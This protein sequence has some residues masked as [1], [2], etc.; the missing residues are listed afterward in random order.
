MQG[1]LLQQSM[2]GI[3]KH[4]TARRVSL[5]FILFVAG[6][7]LLST[8]IPQEMDTAPAQLNAWR[9][10]HGGMLWLI[11]FAHLQRV[12]AQPWFAIAILGAAIS[13]GV[14]AWDQF[15]VAGKRLHGTGI[16]SADEIASNV[17]RQQVGGIAKL[18]RYQPIAVKSEGHLK[19]VKSP[20]G[21]YGN[22]LLHIGMVLAVS[23]SLYVALTGRQGSLVLV[24]GETSGNMLSW[25][26]SEQGLI[27]NPLEMPGSVR[28]DK[29]TVQFD[30]KNQPSLVSSDISIIKPANK[31]D[32]ITSTINS[33]TKYQGMRVY[34]AAQYGDAFTLEFVDAN[35]TQHLEKIPI[36]QPAGLTKAGYG[37]FDLNWSPYI[38]S[39]KYVPD[40]DHKSMTSNNPLLTLRLLDGER[41]MARVNLVRN[42]TSVLGPYQVRLL[43]VE[44]WSKLI[45]VDVS[46]MP[47]VFAGFAVIM[48]GGLIHYLSPPR[49]LIAIRHSDDC[50][51]VYW[52]APSFRAFFVEERDELATALTGC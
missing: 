29:V 23:A 25:T 37:D 27:A 31:I 21:Y 22:A 14:S 4:I 34:H 5:G 52:K 42:S 19:F 10:G 28:L 16:I 32:R 39:A 33:I 30:E 18:H 3:K 1:D 13:L 36:Q 44:K 15:A 24:E 40:A 9:Q 11:D 49:E 17:S 47:L 43:N 12:Y 8:I 2:S 50:Y 38:L 6:M 26:H 41:E 48:L 7:M 20:W 51:R 45:F 46:G 35:G